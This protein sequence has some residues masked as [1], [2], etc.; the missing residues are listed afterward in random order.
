[1][2]RPLDEA[3]VDA[4]HG[5]LTHLAREGRSDLASSHRSDRFGELAR[6]AA[7]GWADL[8]GAADYEYLG[9]EHNVQAVESNQYQFQ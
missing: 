2:S 9:K 1:M 8:F 4:L 5:S 3:R 6:V 7:L